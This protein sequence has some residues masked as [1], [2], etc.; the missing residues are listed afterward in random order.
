MHDT[1]QLHWWQMAWLVCLPRKCNALYQ[2]FHV[3]SWS[4][5]PQNNN[6]FERV[7]YGMQVVIFFYYGYVLKHGPLF[8][9]SL[10]ANIQF[11]RSD[12]IN[13]FNPFI[14]LLDMVVYSLGVHQVT[15]EAH[16]RT[17]SAL[18]SLSCQVRPVVLERVMLYQ[19]W[20]TCLFGRN[21]SRAYK[22]RCRRLAIPSSRE[23]QI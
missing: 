20:L 19:Q 11:Q 17:R 22:R 16:G 23:G 10:K 21:T 14:F 9:W 12:R 18:I 6:A 7:W 2:A 15:Q 1:L 8:P 13:H 4:G 3:A 5:F